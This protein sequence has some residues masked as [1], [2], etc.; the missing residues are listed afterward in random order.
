MN[1]LKSK[2]CLLF[3][4]AFTILFVLTIIHVKKNKC[5]VVIGA[6]NC[7]EQHI[8]SEIL[9]ILIEKKTNLTVIRS[10]NLGGTSIC[11]NALNSGAIDIYFEYTGTA[12]LD[13]LKEPITTQPLHSYLKEQFEKKFNV[14]WLDPLGF[15]NQYV[16]ITRSDMG[17]KKISEMDLYPH[18]RVAFDPEFSARLESSLLKSSYP[19]GWDPKL[20]DSV[21]LYFALLKEGVDVIS[22]ASTDGRLVDSHLIALEDDHHCFPT[23][24]VAPIIRINSLK[25]FPELASIFSLIQGKID[26]EEMSQLNYE[27]E[28]EGKQVNTVAKEFLKR[29]KI[30]P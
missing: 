25:K 17:L 2:L 26:Q 7:T 21:F 9:A 6:K 12:L 29:A 20:M 30:L 13:I 10:F 1:A 23:Y 28:F 11:F 16:L 15:S 18:L 14:T 8:L 4:A 27:V 19:F 3:I 24:E 22:G 5:S